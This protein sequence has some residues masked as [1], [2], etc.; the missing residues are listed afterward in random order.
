MFMF[1]SLFPDGANVLAVYAGKY[2][3]SPSSDVNS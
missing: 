3:N 1:V 2:Y